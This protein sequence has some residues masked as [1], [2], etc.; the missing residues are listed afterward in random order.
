MKKTV[1]KAG[2]ALAALAMMLTGLFMGQAGAASPPS[3]SG[4]VAMV[5]PARIADSRNEFGFDAF[6]PR[7]VEDLQVGG[8]GGVPAN[9]TGVI[10]SITV[11]PQPGSG[12]GSD[13]L[14]NGSSSP[15]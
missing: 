8:R 12:I 13:G 10:L 9:A 3:T 2:A 7:W 11:I 4:Q 15:G 6:G 1:L 14:S 5:S